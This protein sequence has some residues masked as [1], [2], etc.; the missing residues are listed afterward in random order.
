MGSKSQES[1]PD[2]R[3]GLSSRKLKLRVSAFPGILA[4]PEDATTKR[5]SSP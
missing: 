4:L 2:A 5:F 3:H 1:F